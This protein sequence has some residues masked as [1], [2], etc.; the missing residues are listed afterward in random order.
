MKFEYVK[1]NLE[2]LDLQLEGSFLAPASKPDS[3]TGGDKGDE[4]IG[5]GEE[6]GD[7]TDPWG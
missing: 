1:P 2:V 4:V 5:G 7:P 3:G 6:G